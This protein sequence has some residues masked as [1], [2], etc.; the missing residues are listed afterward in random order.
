MIHVLIMIIEK[1]FFWCK[2]KKTRKKIEKTDTKKKLF[3]TS[4]TPNERMIQGLKNELN[5]YKK[6]FIEEQNLNLSLHK[7]ILQI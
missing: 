4:L 7:Y 3:R 1:I 2:S 6:M 5:S